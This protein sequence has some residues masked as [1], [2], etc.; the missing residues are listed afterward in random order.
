MLGLGEEA[1]FYPRF[2]TLPVFDLLQKG[3]VKNRGVKNPEPGKPSKPPYFTTLAPFPNQNSHTDSGEE[4][5]EK[6][7]TQPLSVPLVRHIKAN[8]FAINPKR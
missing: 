2:F 6:S 4:E 8:G 1:I 7:D 5:A 3:Q